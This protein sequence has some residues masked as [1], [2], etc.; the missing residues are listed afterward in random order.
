MSRMSLDS[1][2]ETAT[3]RGLTPV[4]RRALAI[5]QEAN[6]PIGA[7]EMIELMLDEKGKRPAPISVYRA[8]AYLLDHGLAHRLASQNAFVVCGHAHGAEEPVLFL[9]CE[10]CGEV[11]EATSAALSKS[12]AALAREA[13]FA[14]RSRVIEIAGRCQR[15]A[16]A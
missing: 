14:P 10:R 13:G 4:R 15:C 9:I 2:S 1:K 6:R 7:Y 11:K 8:L 12:L 16:A 5:L 3:T